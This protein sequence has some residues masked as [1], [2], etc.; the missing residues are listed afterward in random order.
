M[1]KTIQVEQVMRKQAL[2]VKSSLATVIVEPG[3][4]QQMPQ[5]RTRW[6]RSLWNRE[7]GEVR[8]HATCLGKQFLSCN[9]RIHSVCIT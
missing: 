5:P 1:S 6:L 3:P 7:P 9:S 4:A 8:N 2:D